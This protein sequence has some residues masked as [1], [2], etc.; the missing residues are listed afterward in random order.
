M[1]EQVDAWRWGMVVG[2]APE[3]GFSPV[4]PGVVAWVMAVS[5]F[6]PG[7]VAHH[8]DL[9]VLKDGGVESGLQP[10][11]RCKAGRRT[12]RAFR[13]SSV[14]NN[15]ETT[16]ASPAMGPRRCHGVEVAGGAGAPA[17]G[18]VLGEGASCSSLGCGTSKPAVMVKQG[19]LATPTA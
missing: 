14:S 3:K 5:A 4:A 2:E 9:K 8:H 11:R 6:C 7:K 17:L 13:S 19:V 10:Y 16:T 12:E 15:R 18:H 1:G